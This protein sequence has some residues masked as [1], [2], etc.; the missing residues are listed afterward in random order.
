MRDLKEIREDVK[1]KVEELNE[2]IEEAEHEGAFPRGLR[3]EA[4]T[5]DGR[6]VGVKELTG[7]VRTAYF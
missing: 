6:R 1:A 4:R 2:A 3:L 5:D 7:D